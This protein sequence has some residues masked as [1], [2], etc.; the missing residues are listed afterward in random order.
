LL[1]ATVSPDIAASRGVRV[2]MVGLVYML[3]LAI[4][5][6]LSS[7]AIG[8]I[9]STALLIGPPATAL[10]V[11]KR[12][13]RAI[14]LA[15]LFGLAATWIGVLLAYDSYYWGTAHQ[16]LP[17]SFFVVAV[18]FVGY[19]VAGPVAARTGRRTAAPATAATAAID[20]GKVAA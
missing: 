19:L 15:C 17:V 8:A 1:L 4:S 20:R 10:R 12:T 18:V 9:L 13:S 11:A 6:G 14:A 16:S 5:V 2:R 3:A 7:L